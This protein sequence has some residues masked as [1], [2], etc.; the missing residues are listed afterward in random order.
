MV[1]AGPRVRRPGKGRTDPPATTARGNT[2][3]R[4]SA[5]RALGSCGTPEA[6]QPL[7]ALGKLAEPCAVPA[8]ADLLGDG[9]WWVR[10]SAAGALRRLG[11]RGYEA[12]EDAATNHGGRFAREQ[13]QEALA[14]EE[15]ARTRAAVI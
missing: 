3:E 6:V 10:A 7:T 5:A 12:L 14:L 15:L 2:E 8:L 1:G 13:A 4:I 9:A 11:A